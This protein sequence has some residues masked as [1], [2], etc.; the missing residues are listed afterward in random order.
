M[1][2]GWDAAA[3]EFYGFKSVEDL[4]ATWIDHLKA[5]ARGDVQEVAA[6]SRRPAPPGADG[7]L[8]V[9]DSSPPAR[10]VF[11]PP[12]AARG[13]APAGRDAER[14]GGDIGWN[15]PRARLSEPIPSEVTRTSGMPALK[16]PAAVL[17]P[18]EPAPTR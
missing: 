3:N 18:P 17:L 15:R 7:K 2:N 1:R 16:P 8:V 12:P 10:P 6:N 5:V 4:E 14:F 11:D 13:S 9:F